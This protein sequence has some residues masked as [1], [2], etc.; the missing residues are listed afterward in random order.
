M[1]VAAAAVVV[2]P[3]MSAVAHNLGGALVHAEQLF[4]AAD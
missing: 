4:E 2:V 3:C 1:P